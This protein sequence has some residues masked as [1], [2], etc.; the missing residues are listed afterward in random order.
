MHSSGLRAVLYVIAGVIIGAASA[1]FITRANTQEWHWSKPSTPNL[2][3]LR[4][5]RAGWRVLGAIDSTTV[6]WAWILDLE[7]TST[8][9]YHG[10]VRVTAR[11]ADE[12]GLI[13]ASSGSTEAY[14]LIPPGASMTF[15]GRGDINA[16]FLT[17]DVR[18]SFR[19]TPV[20]IDSTDHALR[21]GQLR[22]SESSADRLYG[23]RM[24]C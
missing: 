22:R 21:C 4:V 10:S 16:R 12:A 2:G 14:L 5:S 19:T 6:E 24:G 13:L 8:S 18:A 7:N 9:S 11:L 23:L 15:Q 20:A 3:G 1:S 17:R